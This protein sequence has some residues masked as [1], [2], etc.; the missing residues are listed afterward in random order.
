MIA[1]NQFGV[2]FSLALGCSTFASAQ[3]LS[4]ERQFSVMEREGNVSESTQPTDAVR[5]ERSSNVD[6]QPTTGAEQVRQR[7]ANGKPQVERWVV[8]DAK[9][10]IVNHGKYIEYDASGATVATGNYVF[11]KRDGTWTQQI[12]VEQA[13]RLAGAVD[14]SFSAPFTSR[15]EFKAGQLDGDWTVSDAR[16]NLLSVW[17]FSQGKREGASS[18]FNSKGDVLQFVTY[19]SNIADG[20]A[21]LAGKGEKPKDTVLTE[22]KMLIQV[23]QWYP[24]GPNKKPVMKSQDWRLELVSLNIVACD[25]ATNHVQY[26]AAGGTAS[27]RHGLAVTFYPNG[28]RE[29]E[30]HYDMGKRSGTF[31]WWYSNGQ[32]KT[33]GEYQNDVEASEWTWWHENGMKQATGLFAA[34]KRIDE[35][36]HWSPDGKLVKRTVA[37]GTHVAERDANSDRLPLR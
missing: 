7:F 29:S 4:L 12:S 18:T 26:Q 33:V 30:G 31:A 15:A 14:K 2:F 11:G 3:E 32:Q 10:N 23:D 24:A 21:K 34:G 9:G 17:S 28:Q 22:G 8:E 13:Q 36:S 35:W 16:G 6:I 37:D 25:W 27:I 5:L 19:K 20:P 1:K